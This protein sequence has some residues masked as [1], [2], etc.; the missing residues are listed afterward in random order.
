VPN[1]VYEF[2][3]RISNPRAASLLSPP[4]LTMTPPN[5]PDGEFRH[6]DFITHPSSQATVPPVSDYKNARRI[7]STVADPCGG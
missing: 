5:A 3:L 7:C 6:I 4:L 2:R 1:C